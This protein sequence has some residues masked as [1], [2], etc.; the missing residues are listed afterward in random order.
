M[1]YLPL[2]LHNFTP[3][4]YADDTALI[5]AHGSMAK[6]FRAVNKEMRLVCHWF[7]ANKLLLNIKKTKYMAIHSSHKAIALDLC[8][9]RVE[10]QP[11]ERV[12]NLTYLGVV[13]NHHFNCKMHIDCAK[14]SVLSALCFSNV[15]ISLM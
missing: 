1:N 4:M 12:N 15:A 7:H 10:G 8:A 14:S 6:A 3:V 11:I 2:M 9:L 5:S 13:L